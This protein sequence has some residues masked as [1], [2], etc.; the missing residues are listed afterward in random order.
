[1]IP[2]DRRDECLMLHAMD[3]QF[4]LIILRL[5]CSFVKNIVSFTSLHYMRIADINPSMFSLE[6][7]DV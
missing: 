6:Q 5:K 4:H 1:M 3:Y 2:S 7:D